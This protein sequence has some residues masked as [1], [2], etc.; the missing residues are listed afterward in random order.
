MSAQDIF[1]SVGGTANERQ[2][3]FVRAVEDRLRAANLVPHTVGRNTFSSGA[4]LAKVIDLLDTC[5]GAVVIALERSFFPAGVEKRG[6]SKE[7]PLADIKLPTPWNH[8]EAAMAYS[9]RLPLLMIVENGLKPEGLLEKGY[10][11][12]VQYL[13][14]S[15]SELGTVEFDGVFQDWMSKVEGRKPASALVASEDATPREVRGL[16]KPPA[17][18]TIAEIV[19]G[20]NV[21]QLWAVLGAIV[22]VIGGAFTAGKLFGHN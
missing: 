13:D 22:V 16:K 12:N 15:P 2:E 1:L 9:R 17:D 4:P 21:V 11:W 20:L 7:T 14:P 8:I 3:S 6:G 19:G 5:S 10:D 18:L